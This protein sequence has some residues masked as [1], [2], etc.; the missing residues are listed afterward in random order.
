MAINELKSIADFNQVQQANLV[1]IDF[2]NES[3][4][5]CKLILPILEKI[6]LNYPADLTIYK[7]DID[8]DFNKQIIVDY[9]V[10]AL[11]TL[12]LIKQGQIVAKLVGF[13]PYNVL[14]DLIKKFR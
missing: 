13:R 2:Y 6:A 7:F 10:S 12:V 14:D 9:Q 1:L 11:P 5:A 4:G 3:C 8:Q